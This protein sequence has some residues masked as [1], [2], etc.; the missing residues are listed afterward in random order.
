MRQFGEMLEVFQ[1]RPWGPH[2]EM[3]MKA[4]QAYLFQRTVHG[5]MSAFDKD[6]KPYRGEPE[7]FL[8]WARPPKPDRVSGAVGFFGIPDEEDE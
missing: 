3:R 7:D 4:H 8:P 5:I 6:P 1:A 2:W